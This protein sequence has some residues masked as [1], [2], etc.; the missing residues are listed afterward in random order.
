[1]KQSEIQK[2]CLGLRP[3]ESLDKYQLKQCTWMRSST[4]TKQCDWRGEQSQGL[5]EFQL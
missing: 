2:K 1:M 5:G 4:N 3:S